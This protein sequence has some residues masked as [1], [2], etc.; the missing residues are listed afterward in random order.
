MKLKHPYRRVLAGILAI[1][2]VAGNTILP[3]AVRIP[4]A[5]TAI[6]ASAA[7]QS[8][9]CRSGQ[10]RYSFT[11][12]DET[13][14]LT[15]TSGTLYKDNVGNLVLPT[16]NN[17]GVN[18]SQNAVTSIVMKSGTYF[19]SDSENLFNGF[20]NLTSFTAEEGVTVKTNNRGYA[21]FGS[22][23]KNCTSL[24]EVDFSGLT[25]GGVI[26]YIDSM[27][28]GCSSLTTAD[29]SS[30]TGEQTGN[31][32]ATQNMGMFAYDP[33][34]DST[35]GCSDLTSLTLPDSFVYNT[36]NNLAN[37]NNSEYQSMTAEKLVTHVLE[38]CNEDMI[39]AL[40]EQLLEQYN[41]YAE[42]QANG[43]HKT[44]ISTLTITVA[45]KTYDGE[46]FTVSIKKN[47]GQVVNPRNYDITFTPAPETDLPVNAGEYSY[48]ITGK[49]SSYTGTVNGTVTIAKATPVLGDV[50]ASPIA[51]N[52]TVADIILSHTNETIPGTLAV[53]SDE[54]TDGTVEYEFTPDDTNNYNVVTGTVSVD[55]AE[56]DYQFD[57]FVWSED[58]TTAQAKLVCVNDNCGDEKLVDADM[59]E[60]STPATCTED[61]FT[62]YTAT[63]GEHTDSKTVT[64]ENTKLGHDF[65]EFVDFVWAEDNKSAQVLV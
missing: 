13:G 41:D 56:H 64:D 65:T 45:D 33:L 28:A 26:A 35:N 27:F 51:C 17:G 2:T 36:L 63:Y 3:G 1:L 18:V 47:N 20:T 44:D 59:N 10:N 61:G 62:V 5:P 37:S 31:G 25:N 38:G 22:M 16:R 58:D 14:V 19:P 43:G 29:L 55:V 21:D 50:T 34:E 6:T 40:T 30:F 53:T 39:A 11:F 8:G 60:A 23:F 52:G 15:I 32:W 57:S 54:I 24:T 48:T 9:T 7:T 49:G 42:V 12:D 4:I 46:P